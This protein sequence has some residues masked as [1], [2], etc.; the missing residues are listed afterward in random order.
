MKR[1]HGSGHLYVKWGSYY[2][3][4][5]GYDGRLVNQKIGKVRARG[6]KNGLTRAEAERALRRLVEADATQDARPVVERPKS[7]DEAANA[8]RERLEL[9]GIRPSYRRNLESMQRVH[10]SPALGDRRADSV[11]REDIERL[12]RAMARRG[13]APKT[14]RNVMT[15]LSSVFSLAIDNGWATV[16]PVSRAARPKRRRHRDADPDIQFLTL[17]ELEAVISAI[18]ADVVLRE[19][20]PS[21]RGRRG[22]APPPPSDVWGPVMRVLILTA[23]SSGLRQSELLGLRWRDLD[24]GSRRVRVRNPFVHGEFS[25][26]GKSDLS[27][28]RS[29]P[30]TD[31]F[32]DTLKDWRS[33]TPFDDDDDLVFAH[34]EKGAPLDRTKV[35]RYF[36][37]ACVTAGVR[38]IRFHDLR[39]TFATTL[40]ASGAPL[41]VIQEFLGHSDLKTTQIYAHYAPSATRA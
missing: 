9:E 21:R 29:V 16:D 34:S 38:V 2:E 10:V 23:A 14:I 26:E 32:H 11:R 3:K 1:S 15:F 31:P 20:A 40:A 12:A 19:P 25:S 24:W 36:Q 18:P 30:M 28:R 37:A 13:L 8:L 4:W 17:D 39:H 6:E 41:R 33:R 5:R 7:V 35:T 22:A 27:T